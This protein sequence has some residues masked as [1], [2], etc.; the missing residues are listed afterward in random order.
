MSDPSPCLS[1]LGTKGRPGTRGPGSGQGAPPL[2]SGACKM[3]MTYTRAN[4][5]EKELG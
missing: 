1:V 3:G 5:W 2:V 4:A